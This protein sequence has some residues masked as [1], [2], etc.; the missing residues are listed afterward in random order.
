MQVP[1]G[2]W[3]E[4]HPKLV[5]H[6]YQIVCITRD[7]LSGQECGLLRPVMPREFDPHS[8]FWRD[9]EHQSLVLAWH[10][11]STGPVHK[12]ICRFTC[13][14]AG[15]LLQATDMAMEFVADHSDIL[16][17]SIA[18]LFLVIS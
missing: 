1:A 9:Y 2:A 16:V 17:G 5:G 3:A 4:R 14:C 12:P 18:V 11:S 10:T 6:H 7:L 8:Y 15:T 13:R